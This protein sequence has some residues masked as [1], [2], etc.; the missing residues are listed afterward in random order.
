MFKLVGMVGKSCIVDMLS[1]NEYVQVIIYDDSVHTIENSIIISPSVGF[2]EMLQG[3]CFHL[4]KEQRANQE[5]I[6]SKRYL[7]IYTNLSDD[8]ISKREKYIEE[9]EK[10]YQV[11]VVIT[12]KPNRR[13]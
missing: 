13:Y 8:V 10:Q 4:A 11:N 3:V 6:S 9:I 2:D 1:R 12:C 5:S 7:V